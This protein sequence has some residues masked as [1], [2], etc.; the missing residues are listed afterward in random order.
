[1]ET[2]HFWNGLITGD[3]TL[4]PYS[5]LLYAQLWKKLFTGNQADDGYIDAYLNELVV[6][7]VSGG[8]TIASGAALVNGGFYENTAQATLSVATPSGNT[9][10]DRVILRKHWGTQTIRLILI[11]GSEGGGAPS[12]SQTEGA[13]WEIPLAQLSV[14]TAGVITV[15]DQRNKARTTLASSGALQHIETLTADGTELTMDF[16]SIPQIYRHLVMMGQ[17]RSQDTAI[18][19]TV[20][21]VLNGESGSISNRQLI[22]VNQ[23]DQNDKATAAI[24]SALLGNMAIAGAGADDAEM[25][26]VFSLRIPFYTNTDFYK[27]LQQNDGLIINDTLN[28]FIIGGESDLWKKTEAINRITITARTADNI[29]ANSRVSLYGME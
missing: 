15:A 9:R 28:N 21:F 12:L 25:N 4:A 20:T 3:A 13:I 26:G 19:E 22:F 16:S 2:S 7:G 18:F 14:T 24:D 23:S 11:S 27:A 1:M 5:A 17:L 29:A 6:S 8:V 10:I